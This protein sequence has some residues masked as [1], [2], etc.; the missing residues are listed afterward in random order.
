[1]TIIN[2]PRPL[3]DVLAQAQAE[4]EANGLTEATYAELEQHDLPRLYVEGFIAGHSNAVGTLYNEAVTYSVG[5]PDE[6]R[7]LQAWAAENLSPA[8]QATF[9]A[10]VTSG[11]SVRACAAARNLQQMRFS[12]GAT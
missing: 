11:N 1:M 7:S 3:A 9:D 6:Y 8:E 12:R 10:D 2:T 4:Y 5:G